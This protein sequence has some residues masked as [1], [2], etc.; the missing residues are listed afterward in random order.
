MI[1]YNII[2]IARPALSSYIIMANKIVYKKD[3]FSMKE[4]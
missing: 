4:Y 1:N 2:Y 3:N